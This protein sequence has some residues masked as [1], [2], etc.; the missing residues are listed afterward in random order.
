[1]KIQSPLKIELE[2]VN[3]TCQFDFNIKSLSI[4]DGV[5]TVDDSSSPKEDGSSM[6]ITMV[7]PELKQEPPAN[8]TDSNTSS[9][10]AVVTTD[11]E[12]SEETLQSEDSE[13]VMVEL[14]EFEENIKNYIMEEEMLMQETLDEILPQWW[15]KEPFK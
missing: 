6:E 9:T 8:T 7:V 3:C 15:N 12:P 4:T 2:S 10:T 14:T 13:E 5:V 1:M 11:V